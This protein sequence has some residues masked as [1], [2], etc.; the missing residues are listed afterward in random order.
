MIG[1]FLTLIISLGGLTLITFSLWSVWSKIVSINE[2]YPNH[3]EYH[4]LTEENVTSKPFELHTLSEKDLHTL[5]DL[6]SFNFNI[7]HIVCNNNTQLI[8]ALIHS[9]PNHYDKRQAIRN[10]WA[11]MIPTL[12]FMGLSDSNITQNKIIEENQ[13]YNDIVQG[14]FIDSYRNLTYKHV[15]VLKWTLYYCPSARYLLKTDDDTFVNA[16]YLLEI[17]NH[18]LSP[19]GARN[20]L[21]CELSMYFM[22]KRS[23]RSKWRVSYAEY[24][25][26]WYP[27]YCRG[28]AIIYSPDVIYKLYKEAQVTPYFW[29]DDV[30]ITGTV[31]IKQNITVTDLGKLVVKES[32][33]INTK[34]LE[35]D[36]VF[37]LLNE[38]E[39]SMKT[40]W[41]KIL[42][43]D[44]VIDSSS[45]I[46]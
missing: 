7:N 46:P 29:I 45:T 34:F 19:L 41:A 21:M 17:L 10:T 8:I 28:W 43:R 15:M 38:A 23:Y 18:K 1:R 26:R 40:L 42:Q 5:I 37:C 9:A 20:L 32:D 2:V 22:V 36:F 35:H 31:A 4:I 16:P 12:F 30:H 39:K 27:I 13:S 11:K 25:D 14:N 44:Y 3:L 6:Q 24:P 33:I